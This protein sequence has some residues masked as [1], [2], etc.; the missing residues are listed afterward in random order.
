MSSK[1]GE[2]TMFVLQRARLNLTTKDEPDA[3]TD[4]GVRLHYFTSTARLVWDSNELRHR[5]GWQRWDLDKPWDDRKP[6]RTDTYEID[7]MQFSDVDL[8]VGGISIPNGA[9]FATIEEV[10][11]R[12]YY[13]EIR[14]DD[15]WKMDDY[16][17]YGL[18]KHIPNPLTHIDNLGWVEMARLEADT[19]LS[20]DDREGSR[21]HQILINGS[22][23]H[24]PLLRPLDA[25][26][27]AT[28]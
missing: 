8:N 24:P 4:S 10:R 26:T 3:G 2:V 14:G 1:A 23:C 19:E 18:F 21:W 7:L 25:A 11:R 17:M 12:P 28:R 9:G 16:V 13:L 15:W 20:V 22:L 5:Q 6:G 27:A